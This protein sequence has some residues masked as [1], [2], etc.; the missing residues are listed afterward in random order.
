MNIPKDTLGLVAAFTVSGVTHLVRP[1]TFE[2]LIPPNEANPDPDFRRWMADDVEEAL[3]AASTASSVTT[4][5]G[6]TPGTST[7]RRCA[8]GR[9]C[10]TA[11]PTGWCHPVHG[12]W[13]HRRI[14][15]AEL[16]VGAGEGPGDTSF[17]H[18][19]EVFGWLRT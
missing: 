16:V 8:S 2:Q 1:E 18:W 13:W 15:H 6:A 10:A 12:E 17:G 14:P 19:D 5:P 3:R 11:V 4:C 7:C 9:C